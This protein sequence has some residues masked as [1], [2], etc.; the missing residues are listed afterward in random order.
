[1]LQCFIW[2]SYPG[3]KLDENQILQTQ[4]ENK[5]NSQIFEKMEKHKF[6][7]FIIYY[8]YSKSQIYAQSAVSRDSTSLGVI[9]IKIFFSGNKFC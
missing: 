6:L 4:K 7:T 9:S 2:N 3:Q 8:Y 5:F 1:M